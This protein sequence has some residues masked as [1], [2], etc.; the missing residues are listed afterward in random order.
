[1]HSDQGH[2]FECQVV[3][4]LCEIAKI[5]KSRTTYH[6]MGNGMAERFNRTLLNMLGTIEDHQKTA[7]KF[8][9]PTLVHAFNSTG[10]EST[11]NAHPPLS[12]V[13]ATS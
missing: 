9:M 5:D 1:M 7:W 12:T 10:N 6:A 13:W 11:G 2:N 8:H 4:E 3:K